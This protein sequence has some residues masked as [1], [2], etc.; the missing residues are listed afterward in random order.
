LYTFAYTKGAEEARQQARFQPLESFPDLLTVYVSEQL[1]PL[2]SNRLL[3]Q[4]R[5]EYQEF[6][7]WLSV[8]SSERDPVVILARSGGRKVT[9]CG[10]HTGH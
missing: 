6:L 3:P 2:F 1:F 5:P 10:S 7:E 8:P 9:G 4:S